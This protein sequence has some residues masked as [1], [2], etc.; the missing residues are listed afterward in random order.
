M[1][2]KN[3]T[4]T[5]N[6]HCETDNEYSKS[7]V[8]AL[9]FCDNAL[10]K[11]NNSLMIEQK[12]HGKTKKALEKEE[13]AHGETKKALEKEESAHGETKK[14]LEKEESA[15]GETKK[16]LEKEESAHGETK[17]ALEKEESAH[18]ETKKSLEKEESA[19]GET[20]KALEKEESAH[21]ETK[22]SLEKEESA[23]GETKKALEKEES[24]HGET[25][26]ALE[27]EESAHRETKNELDNLKHKLLD[28]IIILFDDIS[29]LLKENIESYNNEKLKEYILSII[30]QTSGGWK[31]CDTIDKLL[32]N[33]K[34]GSGAICR[35][36]NLLWW[37]KQENLQYMMSMVN[38]LDAIEQKMNIICEFF[39]IT[40]HTIEYPLCQ[41]SSSIPHYV[42][43]DDQRSNF[44]D[45]FSSENYKNG[46]LCEIRLLSVDDSDGKIYIYYK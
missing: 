26:K 33:C 17:K 27:K 7:L 11:T 44:I 45:I 40:G 2:D 34:V 19:H 36:A 24:A 25:K 4:L 10:N 5:F 12:A 28:K 41:F 3:I 20:K 46:T 14:S 32:Y 15:H 23:H 31:E 16:A 6:I 22:K 8:S 13:S 37:N 42:S 29:S 21:G 43:Y 1:E 18:G 39:K 35:I 9:S 30:D 38:N